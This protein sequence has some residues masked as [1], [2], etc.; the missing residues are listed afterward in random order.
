MQAE[1]VDMEV[2]NYYEKI[3]S[4][5]TVRDKF[6]Y[7]RELAQ[8]MI[9]RYQRIYKGAHREI[10]RAL[11]YIALHYSEE[12]SL[13]DIAEYVGLS[14]NYCSNLFKQEIGENL[15][16]Y[17]NKI[18][19]EKAKKLLRNKSL[20]VYEVA[21]IVGYKNAT[22]LSTMFKKITGVSIS[23]FKEGKECK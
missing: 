5:N 10:R 18:R 4:I 17:V 14:D 13:H 15:T 16:S 2:L 22:Y 23:E 8:K 20:K 12:I 21:G 9:P 11:E 19:I 6:A 1:N 7:T 3:R